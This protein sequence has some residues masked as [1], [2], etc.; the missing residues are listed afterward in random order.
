[1]ELANNNHHKYFALLR[2]YN[3]RAYVSVIVMARFILETFSY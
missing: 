3:L 1:M 2:K